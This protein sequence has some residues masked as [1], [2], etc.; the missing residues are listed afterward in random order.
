MADTKNRMTDIKMAGLT[1]E[2]HLA[3]RISHADVPVRSSLVLVLLTIASH[4]TPSHPLYVQ[5][6][7][8]DLALCFLDHLL[9][10]I[11]ITRF[12]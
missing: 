9:I 1:S 5:L 10:D 7:F 6:A 3:A 8:L 11:N 4:Q 2:R 12:L